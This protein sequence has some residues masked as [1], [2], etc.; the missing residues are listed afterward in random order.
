MRT[1]LARASRRATPGHV[2]HVVPVPSGAARGLTAE[3]YEQMERDFGMLAPPV[4]LHSPAPMVLAACWVMLRETLV[5]AGVAGRPVKEAVAA[6]VS[7]ANRC[8]YCV[9]VHG[10]ALAGLVSGRDAAAV[11]ADRLADVADPE[12]RAAA[13][14]AGD[15]PGPAD[16]RPVPPADQLPELIGVAVTFHYLNRM[17][18]V[19]LQS[20]PFPPALPPVALRGARW[21]AALVMGALARTRRAPGDSLDLLA[22]DGVGPTDLD[23]A[24]GHPTV[25]AAMAR[26]VAAIEAAGTRSVPG[27]VRAVVLDRLA[28][29]DGRP[30]PLGRAWLDEAVADLAE[31]V[32]PAGRLAL[33]TALASYRVVDGDVARF[34][35]AQPG[36]DA[37]VELTAWASLAAARRAGRL[38]RR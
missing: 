32:R 38:L 13:R 17:V 12:I 25:A 3:V 24:A 8:P 28:G 1:L 4:M 19:L 30:P 23:W 16:R 2:Q 26:A 15:G 18:N 27:P 37:L 35:H 14:W 6:A 11:L 29:W 9:E 34:R 36:D 33:L 21:V 5:A 31:P 22:A 20:S 7:R 10:A